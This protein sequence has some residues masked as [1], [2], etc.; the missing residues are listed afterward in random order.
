MIWNILEDPA[1]ICAA[2]PRCLR[3]IVRTLDMLW[4]RRPLLDHSVET[5]KV[6]DGE[7]WKRLLACADVPKQMDAGDSTSL[8][9]GLSTMSS[10]LSI[11]AVEMD[12]LAPET[13]RR[14]PRLRPLAKEWCASSRISDWLDTCLL[15]DGCSR[16]RRQTQHA[17]QTFVLRCVATLEREELSAKRAPLMADATLQH[18][19]GQIRDALLTSGG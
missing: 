13:S 9:Y 8:A 4:R 5:L 6:R 11:F 15:K 12:S 7:L 16:I 1:K 19:C 10:V 17:A 3:A 2:S 18:V 14:T